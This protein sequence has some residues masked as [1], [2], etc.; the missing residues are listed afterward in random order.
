[1]N[2]RKHPGDRLVLGL[3]LI[4]I[5]AAMLLENQGIVDIGSIWRY[6]PLIFVV[7]GVA[8][9]INSNSRNDQSSGIWLLL[10]GLWLQ[11]SILGTWGLGFSETWPALFI[12]FG[13][14][15]LWKNLPALQTS[16]YVKEHGHG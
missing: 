1:M 10:F 7:L 8:K 14:S 4:L 9:L 3:L 15:M 5:G 16:S 11:I 12:I 6:W 2:E 13:V